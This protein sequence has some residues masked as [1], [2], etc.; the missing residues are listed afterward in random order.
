MDRAKR[1]RKRDLYMRALRALNSYNE[2]VREMQTLMEDLVFDIDHLDKSHM[3]NLRG[4]QSR[5]KLISEKP[6]RDF[7]DLPEEV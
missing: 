7:V 6:L 1:K 5:V 3:R 2:A 4:V